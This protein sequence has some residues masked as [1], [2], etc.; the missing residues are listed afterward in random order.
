MGDGADGLRMA[1]SGDE[2][3]IDDS[4]DGPFPAREGSA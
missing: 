1:K 3:T 2:P 4:K